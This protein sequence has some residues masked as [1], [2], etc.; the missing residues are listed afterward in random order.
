MLLKGLGAGNVL[1]EV[2]K[3][4]PI[5]DKDNEYVLYFDRENDFPVSGEMSKKVIRFPFLNRNF[6][7]LNLT[8]PLELTQHKVSLFHSP[9]YGIPL[10]RPCPMITTLY[11]IS[12]EAHP[13]WF[14]PQTARA[15]QFNSR[16]A[17]RHA[18]KI[19]T[20]S[21]Y[22]KQEIIK[23]YGIKDNKIRVIYPAADDFFKKVDDPSSVK[24][25]VA[26]YQLEKPFVMSVGAVHP[27]RNIERLLRVFARLKKDFDM[28]LLLIG[29]IQ[30]PHMDIKGV[31]EGLG[32]RDD[33]VWVEFVS[34]DDLLNL[35]NAAEVFVYPSL[36]EGFGLP[37]AEAMACGVPVVA[38]NATSVP[39]VV[40]DAGIL[41]DPYDDSDILKAVTA[42]LKD[43][44]LKDALSRK[45][46]ERAKRFSYSKTAEE[47]V[48]LYNE[49]LKSL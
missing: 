30:W 35:Y 5:F 18:V 4:I 6:F 13:E 43:P 23:Y 20:I 19:I 36:Y 28:K 24:R 48:R 31:V 27:R 8:L 26:K 15:F 2:V 25:V 9:F 7:W 38:A 39:E 34:R 21:Q 29:K 12:Y 41:F 44:A 10:F 49:V 32:L 45:G 17:A 14:R 22:S 37:V 16:Q 47:T 3:R 1:L 33:V 11:D 42:V 46:M 40:G